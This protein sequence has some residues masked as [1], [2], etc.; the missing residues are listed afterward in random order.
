[1]QRVIYVKVCSMGIV[2]QMRS[3]ESF[4][5]FSPDQVRL[6]ISCGICRTERL[7][8][9][10]GYFRDPGQTLWRYEVVCRER[11]SLRCHD[12]ISRPVSLFGV[13]MLSVVQCSLFAISLF[14]IL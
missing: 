6:L 3:F 9:W 10:H 1:M 2:Y 4:K 14:G 7:F 5:S 11:L 12:S 8:W 13:M